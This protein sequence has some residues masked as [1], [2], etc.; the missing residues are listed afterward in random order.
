M[1]D[2][3]VAGEDMTH[4]FR[5]LLFGLCL[6]GLALT[7]DSANAQR[8]GNRQTRLQVMATEGA[9]QNTSTLLGIVLVFDRRALDLLPQTAGDWFGLQASLRPTLGSRVAVYEVQVQPNNPLFEV[10][11]PRDASRAV[12]VVVYPNYLSAEGQAGA[13]LP[14]RTCTLVVF[15]P[16]TV[17]YTQCR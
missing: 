9:N 10:A 7:A 13:R 3:D 15:E 1:A 4:A 17:S 5:K 6:V 12:A 8:Y 16:T 14:G 11:L 2:R